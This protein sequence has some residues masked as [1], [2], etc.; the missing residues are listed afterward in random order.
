MRTNDP[1]DEAHWPDDLP[2]REPDDDP[3]GED[4]GVHEGARGEDHG[5]ED[6]LDDV[7]AGQWR[8]QPLGERLAAEHLAGRYLYARGV[9]WHHWDG[10]RWAP[11]HEDELIRQAHKFVIAELHRLIDKP[12][13]TDK[14][15]DA[16]TRYRETGALAQLV[17]AARTVPTIS[18]DGGDLDAVPGLLNCANGLVDLRTGELLA[19]DPAR[20][21]TK[22]TGVAY[23]P[24][25]RHRDWDKALQALPDDVTRQWVQEHL[26]SAATGETDR[27]APVVFH[28]GLG[29]NGKSTLI[30][31]PVAALG[32][33]AVLVP[34]KL[35]A[36]D[37]GHETV[38]M[39]LRGARLAYL[40]ELPE[41][42]VLPVA[43]I[44]KL[45]STPQITA[46]AIGKDNVTW[47]A[48]HVLI[49][50]TNYFPRV[51]E[52]DHGTWRR[53]AMID[54][55][56]TFKGAAKD[57]QLKS[58]LRRGKA[59]REAVLAWLVEGA[60]RWYANGCDTGELPEAVNEAT[61]EWRTEGDELGKFLNER[62]NVTGDPAHRI[63]TKD[64]LLHF[65]TWLENNRNRAW[66][67]TLLG[68]RL[69][70]HH[71]VTEN[72]LV[73]YDRGDRGRQATGLTGCRLETWT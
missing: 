69:R 36:N 68:Q 59:Q 49:V 40:E 4:H 39:P 43:R 67:L 38:W 42:H 26:G 1:Y 18:V 13:D 50:A 28:K 37:S 23:R 12:Y 55:P 63:T 9:G 2:L 35:L 15:V 73:T 66:S 58:R 22:T 32:D 33:F 10:T 5:D 24:E 60:R 34:D 71:F 52:T 62:V 25:A 70:S 7:D 65:N 53:L 45:A 48:T 6:T 3:Y 41:E 72:T 47:D 16:V 31:G 19:H 21:I 54:Y 14:L 20:L 51:N 17:R 64:L 44:K 46:R 29:A 30:G 11:S 56:H 8:S 57:T 27:D 61:A